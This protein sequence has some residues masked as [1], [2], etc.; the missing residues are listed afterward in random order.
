MEEEERDKLEEELR[1]KSNEGEQE[2]TE[3]E[4]ELVLGVTERVEDER[5]EI[6]DRGPEFDCEKN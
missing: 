6:G 2:A 5:G 3:E 1:L 4:R